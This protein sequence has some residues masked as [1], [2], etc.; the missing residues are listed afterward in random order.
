MNSAAR[1]ID[2]A[3]D[4][5]IILHSRAGRLIC[6]VTGPQPGSD[7]LEALRAHKQD[8]LQHLRDGGLALPTRSA[9]VECSMPLSPLKASIYYEHLLNPDG[10]AYNMGFFVKVLG[11]FDC[12]AWS[13]AWRRLLA[14]H[15]DLRSLFTEEDGCLRQWV[16]ADIEPPLTHVDLSSFP[17]EQQVAALE[18]ITAATLDAPFDLA[19]KIPL[20]LCVA[21][22]APQTHVLALCL[23]HIVADADSLVIL[24]HQLR[25]A[26]SAFAPLAPADPQVSS[27]ADATYSVQHHTWVKSDQCTRYLRQWCDEVRGAPALF[28][29]NAVPPGHDVERI[30]LSIPETLME[31]LL[32]IGRSHCF[33]AFQITLAAFARTL[34]QTAHQSD[35]LIG[36]PVRIMAGAVASDAVGCFVNLLPVR[37]RP[38]EFDDPL[39]LLDRVRFR[40]QDCL[41]RAEVPLQSIRQ[42]LA[43]ER[44]GPPPAIQAVLTF[45]TQTP[46]FG[47]WP[48]LQFQNLQSR[49]SQGKFGLNLQLHLSEGRCRGTVELGP[50]AS[51][52]RG[53]DGFGEA[54]VAQLR[55]LA[56]RAA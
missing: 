45:T 8:I 31:Q 48:G 4:A 27:L 3:A 26:Y 16:L 42:C 50:Q 33:T 11:H 54:F 2:T 1:L 19:S 35:V 52:V 36:V 7:L 10:N 32:Q 14:R 46:A 9:D 23:H 53:M 15:C 39:A 21:V 28:P 25:E 37:L 49:V 17:A 51:G 6:A 30:P 44:R 29:L 18:S 40:M 55:W 22:L 43:A 34:A 20:R 47:D 5:G 41:T 12:E 56:A 38:L 13:F 24:M